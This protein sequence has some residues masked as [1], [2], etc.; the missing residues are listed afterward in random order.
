M[1]ARPANALSSIEC[2]SSC[3]KEQGDLQPTIAI[4]SFERNA[5]TGDAYANWKQRAH[6]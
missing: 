2:A 3:S 4:N 5:E 1:R 6:P